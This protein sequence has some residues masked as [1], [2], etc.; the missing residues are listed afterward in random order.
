VQ[1]EEQRILEK[2]TLAQMVQRSRES[3][4]LSYQ[5]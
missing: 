1:Q 3:D 4:V 2:T 5:I